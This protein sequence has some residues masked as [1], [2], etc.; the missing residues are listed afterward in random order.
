MSASSGSSESGE[1]S[2]D[3]SEEEAP[4]QVYGTVDSSDLLRSIY[5]S[6][7]IWYEV[8]VADTKPGEPKLIP[9]IYMLLFPS[10]FKASW[11][12]DRLYPNV[13]YE[14]CPYHAY[15]QK[16]Y[17]LNCE[18][19]DGLNAYE[20][21][22]KK[23]IELRTEW[24][25]GKIHVP[26][27]EMNL[28]NNIQS[29]ALQLVLSNSGGN[30]T[31]TNAAK[32]IAKETE[33]ILQKLRHGSSAPDPEDP[34]NLSTQI[35][36]LAFSYMYEEEQGCQSVA[37]IVH[38]VINAVLVGIAKEAELMCV[39]LGRVRLDSYEIY[40]NREIRCFAVELATKKLSHVIDPAD[41]AP[42][43]RT[44]G[45]NKIKLAAYIE[46]EAEKNPGRYVD[47]I[48]S[49]GSDRSSEKASGFENFE[50]KQR[51]EALARH[52]LSQGDDECTQ[53]G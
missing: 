3:E 24:L 25:T 50:Q 52:L 51:E 49:E 37:A 34:T 15:L 4:H 33:L 36:E 45:E 12:Y 41:M 20:L 26:Q 7:R 17:H 46:T 30:I 11:G 1:I 27:N 47:F 44:L 22:L 40:L 28:S 21:C 39:N 42:S 2:E 19:R 9:S 18:P 14:W 53:V 43:F 29:R 38:L 31:A 35:R 48:D 8:H 16:F 13:L 6:L 23:E 5:D 10:L 32:C